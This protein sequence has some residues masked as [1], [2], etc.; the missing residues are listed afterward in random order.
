[1]YD[2]LYPTFVS[3][4]AEHADSSDKDQIW[5]G[6]KNDPFEEDLHENDVVS[7]VDQDE[8]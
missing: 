4:A 8:E 2:L 5:K 6:A 1:M 3:G 7:G